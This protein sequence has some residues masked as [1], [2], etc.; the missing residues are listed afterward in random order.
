ALVEFITRR[1]GIYSGDPPSFFL[2]SLCDVFYSS[3]ILDFQSSALQTVYLATV[4]GY[5]TNVRHISFHYITRLSRVDTPSIAQDLVTRPSGAQFPHLVRNLLTMEHLLNDADPTMPQFKPQSSTSPLSLSQVDAMA[6]RSD[7]GAPNTP[8]LA[9]RGFREERSTTKQ[10]EDDVD[11]IRAEYHSRRLPQSPTELKDMI[12]DNLHD[13]I[14]ITWVLDGN[15]M[16]PNNIPVMHHQGITYSLLPSTQAL[17]HERPDEED[18]W[19]DNIQENNC[20]LIEYES[21]ESAD[22]MTIKR[23]V[24]TDAQEQ[25]PHLFVPLGHLSEQCD[26]IA[27]G[28]VTNYVWAIDVTTEPRSLWLI[29][30]YRTL[31]DNCDEAI[32][33]LSEVYW[34]TCG[35]CRYT[36][37][38]IRGFLGLGE[39]DIVQVLDDI[40]D[41]LPSKPVKAHFGKPYKLGPSLRAYLTRD[42]G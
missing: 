24:P 15:K 2:S 7:S 4:S 41:W 42:E 6:P 21:P 40:G 14:R 1:K 10:P 11:A 37:T 12:L 39:W 9:S 33:D 18:S 22:Q 29:F 5:H 17:D 8:P 16:K 34:S 23:F 31:D 26:K 25:E 28:H 20:R 19:P 27:R 13:M 35:S 30:D 32:R 36:S 3:C 38:W